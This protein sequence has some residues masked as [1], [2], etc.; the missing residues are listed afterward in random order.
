[1][2]LSY[3]VPNIYVGRIILVDEKSLK[4]GRLYRNPGQPTL[5]LSALSAVIHSID[6]YVR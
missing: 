4:K 5:L 3:V 1:M 2:Y 6:I